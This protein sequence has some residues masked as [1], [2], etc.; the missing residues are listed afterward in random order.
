MKILEYFNIVEKLINLFIANWFHDYENL[1]Y[2]KLEE[3]LI[4]YY[5]KKI[6]K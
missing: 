1:T 4:K 6:M 5:K 3:L 2:E